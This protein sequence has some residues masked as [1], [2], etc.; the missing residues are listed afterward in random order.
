MSSLSWKLIVWVSEVCCLLLWSFVTS[1]W[2]PN[3]V[4]NARLTSGL[5][6]SPRRKIGVYTDFV[7][8][9]IVVISVVHVWLE[10]A[11]LI[12]VGAM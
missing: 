6:A 2:N 3:I 8:L 10:F 1:V 7:F 11:C 5:W 4:S 12:Y 9:W